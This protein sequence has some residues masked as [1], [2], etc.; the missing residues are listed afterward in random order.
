MPKLFL[1][2]ID[3]FLGP[4]L[5]QNQ[6]CSE[7][8]EIQPNLYFKYAD[9]DFKVKKLYKLFTTCQVQIDPKIKNA[10][11]LLKLGTF[12]IKYIDFDFNIKNNFY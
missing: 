4:D 5:F 1:S 3:H 6:K 10:Q 7:F 8:I 2:N 11:N 9:F 12:D